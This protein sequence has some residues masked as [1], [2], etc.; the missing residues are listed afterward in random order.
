MFPYDIV[1]ELIR[2]L[3]ASLERGRYEEFVAAAHAALAGLDCNHLGPGVVFRTLAGVQR[4]H[5]DPPPDSTTAHSFPRHYRAG[6][7]KLASLPPIGRPD[8]AEGGRER[9]QFRRAD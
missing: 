8:R 9:N 5:W 6:R 3:G 7:T 2:E 4:Q 1:D